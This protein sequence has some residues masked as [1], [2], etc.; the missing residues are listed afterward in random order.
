MMIQR[1]VKAAGMAA[2]IGV[3]ACSTL[4]QQAQKPL[5]NADVVNMLRAGKSKQNILT[6]IRT[7]P[8]KFDVSKQARASFDKGC[9]AIKPANVSTGAWAVEIGDVWNLMKNVVICQKT[10]GRGG[11]GACDLIPLQSSPKNTS[12][13]PTPVPSKGNGRRTEYEAI[14]VERGVTNDTGFSNWANSGQ[15]STSPHELP[16]LPPPKSNPKR[17]AAGPADAA[18]RAE[19]KRKLEAQITAFEKSGPHLA[20]V[21]IRPVET[22]VREAELLKRQK[23][24][25]EALRKQG[26]IAPLKAGGPLDANSGTMAATQ[27]RQT[28][29]QTI[30]GSAPAPITPTP[31][32]SVS[33]S[34]GTL[35]LGGGNNG[36]GSKTVAPSQVIA[37]AG[38]P[39]PSGGT[40]LLDGGSN[41]NSKTAA[42]T[43]QT[44]TP[45][46]LTPATGG[47]LLLGGGTN[48]GN[49]R[50]V[51][52][53][54]TITLAGA[55]EMRPAPT[56]AAQH[57]A[58]PNSPFGRYGSGGTATTN[59]RLAA[60]SV[61][62]YILWD[63]ST[64]HY[65]LSAPCQGLKVT[66]SASS[67]GGLQALASSTSFTTPFGTQPVWN[68]SGQGSQGPWMLCTYAFFK[69]P[70]EVPLEVDAVVTQQSAFT[71]P[72]SL[73][74]L[75]KNQFEIS[76]GNC[77]TTPGSTLGVVLNSGTILCG[78]YAFNVNFAGENPRLTATLAN[79]KICAG[80]QIYTV[81]G[82]NS[83]ENA[84]NPV[85]FTQDP[86]YNDYIIT[87]CGFGITEGGQVYLSG[88][89]TGGR[90]NMTVYQWTPT[91]IEARVQEGLT[92]VLDGW[93]DLIVVPPG[94][95]TSAKF[96][97]CRFY[98]QRQSVLLPS[99]PQQYVRLD[100]E[101]L[102]DGKH[103]YPGLQYC[104]GPNQ[105][106]IPC[107][108]YDTNTSD[109][110]NSVTN[111]VD[112]DAGPTKFNPGED[113]YD[114]SSLAPGF[115]IDWF[116]SHWYWYSIRSVCPA[117]ANFAS[118]Q[119]GDS[120]DFDA[121]LVS[122]YNYYQ[123]N[124]QVVVNWGVDHCSWTGI[125]GISVDD[126][127]NS[128]YSLEVH[129]NGPIGVD[130]W[131]GQPTNSH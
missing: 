7:G 20:K 61:S 126:Y 68:F 131:T 89:V 90:I 13:S 70:E 56:S 6:T 116:T 18:T 91:L 88:A 50:T 105:Y 30:A 98:A 96:A 25:V 63:T 52:P 128:G 40:L 24:F 129:I 85:V 5:T 101:Q 23:M 83:V 130:P 81:N 60:G 17:D 38:S 2:A 108:S 16:A 92:G 28:N 58:A 71:S 106:L 123:N 34:G 102:G 75:Q 33:S 62:G 78:D 79:T 31:A 51:A 22:S 72:V 59:V 66:V 44:I 26:V 97:N 55:P 29:G 64:V 117:W 99:I 107:L 37:P 124:K 121:P 65:Q 111:A 35:L 12:A 74:P 57:P 41:P 4:A 93:P 39:S 120:V 76:G 9:A 47:T 8:A 100:S 82:V 43:Q 10:N 125:F 80:T 14:T 45:V 103:G 113:V 48:Q 94:G 110:P 1:I 42:P 21:T 54:Q 104:P 49:S 19:I 77:G 73:P 3:M 46:G 115:V 32:G 95:G 122:Q 36:S 69:L 27:P 109:P 119:F 86:A 11:E 127:Y 15:T 118:K 53:P 114:L 84:S 112:R 67:S 87:G